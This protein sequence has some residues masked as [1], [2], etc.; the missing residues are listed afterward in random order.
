MQQWLDGAWSGEFAT[1]D[2]LPAVKIDTWYRKWAVVA[3]E[4]WSQ[5]VMLTHE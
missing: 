5:Q 3:F 1:L 2:R 4:K